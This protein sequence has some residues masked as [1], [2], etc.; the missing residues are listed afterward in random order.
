[1]KKVILGCLLAGALTGLL[2]TACRGGHRKEVATQPDVT[3]PELSREIANTIITAPEAVVIV[4]HKVKDFK[5]WKSA[6]DSHDSARLKNGLHHYFLGRGLRD[7]NM[8]VVALRADE[9]KL[10]KEFASGEDLKKIMKAAGV[11]GPPVFHFV[12]T[13]WQDTAAMGYPL[14]LTTFEVKDGDKW[15]TAFD[16][17]ALEREQ[18]GV[19]ARIVARAYEDR[20]KIVLVTAL[21]DTARAFQ[22]FNSDALK[23]RREAGGVKGEPERFIFR[24]VPGS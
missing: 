16:E 8:V 11:S 21:S 7:S 1:M 10:A 9:M 14:S 18:H 19:L 22:Y 4:M 20:H 24:T 15:R 17:G 5:K 2:L 13:V 6:Y 23:K 12:V 3:A